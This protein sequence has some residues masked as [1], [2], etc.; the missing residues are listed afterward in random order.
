MIRRALICLGIA[1]LTVGVAKAQCRQALALG[2]DV[3]GSV[4]SA[5]YQLQ[6]GGLAKALRHPDVTKALLSV[7]SAPVYIA[8]FE[9]SGP[10]YQNILLNWTPISDEPTL[11][12][13]SKRLETATRTPAPPATALGQ[14]MEFGAALLSQ[15]PTC[16][17]QTLD[18]S[19]DGKN[20]SGPRP[21]TVR[22]ILKDRP[23]TI[24]ALVI[25]ADTRPE[26]GQRQ[27]GIAEL[28]SYFRAYVILGPDAFVETALGFQNYE[29]AMVR[30]LI[31][32]LQG[33]VLSQ[34]PAKAP[35]SK[36][37]GSGPSNTV[38]HV[39]VRQ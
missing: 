1:A 39:S 27:V 34:R 28:S 4:D 35:I 2:L 7:P 30:K 23:I 16:W 24:N 17:K 22:D 38:Q 15:Q 37:I 12:A 26:A 25:G 14:A 18:I 3:S 36:Y 9:W 8:V 21:E 31:R 33:Q 6:L 19:G 11:T 32:E 20:N 29:A 10:D 5:E 13:V